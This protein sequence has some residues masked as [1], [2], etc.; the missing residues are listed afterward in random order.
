M[1]T[2]TK[3]NSAFTLIEM[4]GSEIRLRVTWASLWLILPPLK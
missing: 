3:Q 2:S 1:E 4:I